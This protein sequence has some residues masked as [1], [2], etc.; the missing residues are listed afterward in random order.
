[1]TTDLRTA[2]LGSWALFCD[3]SGRV[4]ETIDSP[5]ITTAAVASPLDI[6]AS[7]REELRRLFPGDKAKWK[8]GGRG[9]LEKVI[10]VL[11]SHDL[12]AG[13]YQVHIADP[14]SW[15]NY[16]QQGKE[17]IGKVA[18][19]LK[20]AAYLQPSMTLRMRFL[21]GAFA[22]LAGRLMRSGY[23]SD[24][25]SSV[26]ELDITVDTDFRDQETEHQFCES[27]RDWGPTSRLFEQLRV[28]PV[29][30]D[31]R[32]KTE[33][34]EPLLLLPDYVA[35]VYHHADPRTR[36]G[37]PVMAPKEASEAVEDLRRRLG[38]GRLLYEN[39]EDF[40]DEYPLDLR[41]GD[42]IRRGE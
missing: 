12:S 5:T 34:D 11:A 15:A 35:G 32:C 9:G 23:R 31:V 39:P 36:L 30:R 24:A 40:H 41:D 26:I 10:S 33:Q 28:Q 8:Y 25:A 37:A 2:H 21:A 3:I 20:D 7:V 14:A 4:R 17:F 27:V 6:T 22:Q 13:V 18:D 42:V 19:D 29:V 1:V 16:F 38:V